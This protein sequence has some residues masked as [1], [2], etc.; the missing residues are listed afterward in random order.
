MSPQT[1]FSG[2]PNPIVF[3]SLTRGEADAALAV[4][5]DDSSMQVEPLGLHLPLLGRKPEVRH[6][7]SNPFARFFGTPPKTENVGHLADQAVAKDAETQ[8]RALSRKLR[9]IDRPRPG[10]LL[11]AHDGRDGG[12]GDDRHE[13]PCADNKPSHVC[14]K[15]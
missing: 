8:H 14:R 7:Q 10:P 15:L 1:A 2:H 6:R 13:G 11:R 4:P 3:E 5:S 9:G 12:Q